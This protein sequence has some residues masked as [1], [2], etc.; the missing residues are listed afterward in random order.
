M[1]PLSEFEAAFRDHVL[2]I[3]AENQ[4]AVPHKQAVDVRVTKDRRPRDDRSAASQ[5]AVA[6]QY[7]GSQGDLGNPNVQSR[8]VVDGDMIT[9]AVEIQGPA[10]HTRGPDGAHDLPVAAA[11]GIG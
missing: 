10:A 1:L 2:A 8:R 5:G 3:D 4:L 9:I 6:R 7:P 11:L